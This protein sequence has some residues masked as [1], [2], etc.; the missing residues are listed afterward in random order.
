MNSYSKSSKE[1]LKTCHPELQLLF[2]SVLPTH[3]HTILVGHRGEQEQNEAVRTGKSTLLYP[4]GKHN[5][6][7]SMAVDVSPYPIDWNDTKRFYYFGGI[8]KGV[9][10]ELKRQGLM[11][12][13]IRFGGDWDGDNNLNDQT[14][15]DLVHWELIKR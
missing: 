11:D 15:N 8:V 7:P 13:D 1:K 2:T 10:A 14:F 4:Y 5:K 9:A 6:V 12:Y 3:D